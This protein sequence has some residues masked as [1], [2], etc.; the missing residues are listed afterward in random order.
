MA[1]M[2]HRCDGPV[3]K[4]QVTLHRPDGEMVIDGE[5]FERW[6]CTNCEVAPPG[7]R[8]KEYMGVTEDGEVLPL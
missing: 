5:R 3:C 6:K 4:G 7:K 2:M 1:T 8:A